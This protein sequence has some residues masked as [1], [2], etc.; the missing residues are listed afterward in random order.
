[1]HRP[2]P[3]SR[4]SPEP[5]CPG[6]RLPSEA[7]QAVVLM[8]VMLAVLLAI[9]G[10]AIDYGNWMVSRRQVQN[11]A[12]AAALAAA[13]QIPSGGTT[14]QSTG[15]A[16][17]AENGR[18]GDAVTITQA[19]DMTTNDSVQVTATRTV[20]TWFTH[21]LGL[22]NVKVTASARATIESFSQVNGNAMPWGVLQASYVP[23]QQY[24]IYT[25]TTSNANN[26]ALSLPYVSGTN[27]P[28]PNGAN[29]YQNEING[30]LP[31]CPISVGELVDTKTGDNSGPTAQGLNARITTWKPVDQIV[32]ID[33]TG[34]VT[35]I[36]DP[37]NPQLVMIPVLVNPDGSNGW[38]SGSSSP[39]KV[40]GFAWFVITSCGDP[41][42]PTY[43]GNSDGK[44]VNGVFVS[45]DS[46]PDTGTGG[47]WNP[48]SNTAYTIALTK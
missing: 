8:A 13:A 29:A 23:G 35:S 4:R 32:Q 18:P 25:K 10:F 22:S 3:T 16:Q 5:A 7:G 12:D 42:H 9:A 33:G 26:G 24:S 48:G 28:D 20:S 41:A 37:T 17:Y 36:L 19:T 11:A 46:T 1:M 21:V 6:L 27:C 2:A 40:V 43:C 34:Q 15:A 14:I 38:P 39:M 47:Q 44:Q 30:T 45:M 31:E